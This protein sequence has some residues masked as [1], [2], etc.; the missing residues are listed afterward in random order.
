MDWH[1]AI[2]GA[3]G[4]MGAN[5]LTSK[6]YSRWIGRAWPTPRAP[7]SWG[8]ELSGTLNPILGPVKEPKVKL[9]SHTKAC[10]FSV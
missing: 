1:Q 5:G 6:I 2:K 4:L 9:D 3:N 7:F 8:R 10:C